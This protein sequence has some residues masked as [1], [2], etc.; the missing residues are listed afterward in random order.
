MDASIKLKM[1]I[2]I[3]EVAMVVRSLVQTANFD[4]KTAYNNA[5][6]RALTIP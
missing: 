4:H 6:T 1:I 5:M 2:A 3:N